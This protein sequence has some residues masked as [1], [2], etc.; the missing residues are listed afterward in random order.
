MD[1]VNEQLNLEDLSS[2]HPGLSIGLSTCYSEAARVCLDRHHISPIELK[3]EDDGNE[4]K[5]ECNWELSD[6][7]LK[8]AYAN[9]IDTTEFGAYAVV[10]ATVELTRRLVAV[11]RAETKTGADYYLSFIGDKYVD[12][13]KC[14]RLEVSGLNN[15]FYSNVKKRLGEKLTQAQA[16]KSNLPAIAGVVGFGPKTIL[17]QSLE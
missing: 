1:K 5:I 7:M 15:G 6:E 17:I 10:L 4:K 16:G 8:N 3:V 9:E 12:F 11:K 2:R 14:I 13:E